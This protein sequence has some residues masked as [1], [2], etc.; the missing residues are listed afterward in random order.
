MKMSEEPNNLK[1]CKLSKIALKG[2]L[3]ERY[4]KKIAD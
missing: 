3:G 4:G 2:F 1:W